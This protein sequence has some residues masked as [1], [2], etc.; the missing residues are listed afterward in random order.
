MTRTQFQPGPERDHYH[1]GLGVDSTNAGS[2]VT[3]DNGTDP[4]AAVTTLVAPGADV[5]TP[6]QADLAGVL[7]FRRIGPF[8]VAFDDD[9]AFPGKLL[10]EV[11]ADETVILAWMTPKATLDGNAGPFNVDIVLH[12]PNDNY[13]LA[14]YLGGGNEEVE[15]QAERPVGTGPSSTIIHRVVTAGVACELRCAL[16]DG[17]N[18]P[19]IAGEVYVNALI[20][21]PAS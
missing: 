19:L 8:A 7:Q 2:G 6:G 13:S 3:V 17:N 12:S 21:T 16:Y 18:D 14:V 20:A 11:A 1:D 15:M 4:P 5:S 10:A 9:V